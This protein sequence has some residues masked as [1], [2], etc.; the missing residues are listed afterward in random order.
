MAHEPTIDEALERAR[1]VQEDRITAIRT[2][3]EARQNLTDTRDEAARR[4]AEVQRETAQTIA[5]AEREDVRHYNA[6]LTAGW[7][8]ADLRK[9]GYNEPAKKA[10]ARRR[11][12]AT[13][14]TP[15]ATDATTDR[16][17]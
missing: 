3:A 14:G 5:A 12:T 11:A 15:D 4:I 16:S 2:L 9:I 1:R 13:A 7:T 8:T 17:D 10:R 6:A